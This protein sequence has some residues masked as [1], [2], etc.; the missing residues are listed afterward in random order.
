MNPK[1][2]VMICTCGDKGLEKVAAM[3]LPAVDGVRYLVSCQST[4]CR[5]PDTLIRED[6]EVRYSDTRGL[7]NNRNEALSMVTAPYALIADDDLKF[8]PEGLS[9]IIDIF[10]RNHDVDVA[11]FRCVYPFEKVYPPGQ[12]DLARNYRNYYLTSF[13]IALRTDAVRRCRLAFTPLMGIGAPYLHSGEENM[14]VLSA[15]RSGLCGRFFPVTIAEHPGVP[16]GEREIASAGV[17]RAQGAY[18]SQAFGLTIVPR[19]VLK[20]WRSGHDTPV[21]FMRNLMYVTEGAIYGMRHG[22]ALMHPSEC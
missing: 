5:L 4:P 8:R 9:S 7:S 17:L 20:A 15:L 10:E 13:E 2:D 12:H 14:F 1:L 16:T 21:R 3:N 11:T 18:I 19:I 22:R 6:I